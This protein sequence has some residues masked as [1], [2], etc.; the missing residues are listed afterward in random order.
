MEEAKQVTL[1]NE[2]RHHAGEVDV[3]QTGLSMTWVER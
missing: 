2:R 1:M 3:R